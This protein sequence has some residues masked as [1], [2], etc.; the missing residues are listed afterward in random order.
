MPIWQR[1]V[2]ALIVALVLLGCGSDDNTSGGQDWDVGEGGLDGGASGADAAGVDGGAAGSSPSVPFTVEGLSAQP[3]YGVLRVTNEPAITGSMIKVDLKEDMSVAIGF[4]GE[5][6][7][8]WEIFNDDRVRLYD[9]MRGDQ[10][11]Q[12]PEFVLEA[13][14]QDDEVSGLEIYMPQGPDGEPYMVRYEPLGTPDFGLDEVRGN[15]QSEQTFTGQNG[16]SL[17]LAVR[18]LG[19]QAG[20]GVYN[21]AYVEFSSGTA[22]LLTYET[23]ETFW[24]IDP[25]SAGDPKWALGGQIIENDQGELTLYAPRQ[26]NPGEQPAEFEA[27]KMLEVDAFSVEE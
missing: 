22:R 17:R 19:D 6:T 5:V 20:Y 9:L 7:G 14:M 23:G 15:W 11:N 1:C 27:T 24:F 3:F 18:I 16:E 10:P 26:T 21:G 13:D 25:P 8:S 4:R 2:P 12:P